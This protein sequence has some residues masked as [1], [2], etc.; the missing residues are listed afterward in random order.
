MYVDG[1]KLILASYRLYKQQYDNMLLYN[2]DWLVCC[3]C[4]GP[5]RQLSGVRKDGDYCVAD[6]VIFMAELFRWQL[7][8]HWGATCSFRGI[9]WL[10]INKNESHSCTTRSSS[11]CQTSCSSFNSPGHLDPGFI[12]GESLRRCLSF[13]RRVCLLR[14]GPNIPSTTFIFYYWRYSGR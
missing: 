13:E 7:A 2:V 9:H 1:D 5:P 12:R 8:L 6:G 4:R 14:K 11:T 3:R 10:L